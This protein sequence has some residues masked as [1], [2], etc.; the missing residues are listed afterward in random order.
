MQGDAAA[1]AEVA[2]LEEV[3][4]QSDADLEAVKQDAAGAELQVAEVQAELDG[5]G[6]EPMRLQKDR[7]ETLKQV[8]LKQQ[9]IRGLIFIIDEASHHTHDENICD[10]T[11]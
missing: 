4:A 2:R 3:I 7:V 11:V 10:Q 5:I 9:C 8:C 1:E 6:G